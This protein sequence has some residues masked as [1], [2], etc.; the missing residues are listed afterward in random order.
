MTLGVIEATEK[1][2]GSQENGHETQQE[3]NST[4][5]TFSVTAALNIFKKERAYL[6]RNTLK[7]TICICRSK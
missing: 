6:M 3:K 7:H 4:A 2:V 5:G 1:L